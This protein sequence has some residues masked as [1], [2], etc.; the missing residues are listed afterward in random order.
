MRWNLFKK[1][2]QIKIKY[3]MNRSGHQFAPL[4]NYPNYLTIDLRSKID[5]S[6][7][8]KQLLISRFSHFQNYNTFF[9]N[10]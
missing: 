9:Q 1:N 7:Y 4:V 2:I 10:I 8:F 3:L 5:N 6:L